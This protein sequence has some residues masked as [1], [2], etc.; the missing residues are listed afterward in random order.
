[1]KEEEEEEEEEEGNSK[2]KRNFG[3]FAPEGHSWLSEEMFLFMLRF[4]TA[5]V[6]LL[7][8]E[9]PTVQW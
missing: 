1:M 6:K 3:N 9:S 5:R 7:G 8:H 2:R 4:L